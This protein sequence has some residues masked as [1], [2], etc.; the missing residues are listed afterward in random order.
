MKNKDKN[1]LFYFKRN[2]KFW[3]G[4][5][6]KLQMAFDKNMILMLFQKLFQLTLSEDHQLWEME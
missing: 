6:F 4:D 5:N 1:I 3:T 2:Y